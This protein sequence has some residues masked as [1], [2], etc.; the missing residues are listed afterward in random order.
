MFHE[1]YCQLLHP[2]LQRWCQNG[3]MG[4]YLPRCLGTCASNS[5]TG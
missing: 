5:P 4:I 2:S 3:E 1:A